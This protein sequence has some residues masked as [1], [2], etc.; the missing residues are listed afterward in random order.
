MAPAFVVRRV[1]AAYVAGETLEE[2]LACVLSLAGRGY[3]A[4]ID[5]LGE[6]FVDDARADATADTYQCVLAAVA[7]AQVP[8]GVSLKLSALGVRSLRANAEHRLRTILDVA[9]EA[10]RFVRIDMEEAETIDATLETYASVKRAGYENVGVVLQASMRRSRDDARRL[11]AAGVP[12]VRICKGIY[13]EPA[14]VS[15]TSADDVRANFVDVARILMAAGGRVAFATHD[16]LLIEECLSL[17]AALKSPANQH[18]FQ[19]LLGVREDVR[20]RLRRRGEQVR[21]YVPYGPDSVQYALRR[22]R[23]NPTIARHVIR[24]LLGRRN[25]HAWAS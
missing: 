22:V 15:F 25:R 7:G 14:N 10:G 23:E 17:C 24:A 12:D 8:A 4:T 5:L 18:E 11:V 16:E 9:R 2:A 20:D 1:A 19:M 13:I 21:I 3:L 6:G